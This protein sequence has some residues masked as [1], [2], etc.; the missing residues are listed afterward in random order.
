L[1]ND[2]DCLRAIDGKP[3]VVLD[4]LNQFLQDIGMAPVEKVDG[5]ISI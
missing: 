4:R 5:W 3:H 2:Y 1:L